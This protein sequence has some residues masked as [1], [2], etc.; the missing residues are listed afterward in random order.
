[1]EDIGFVDADVFE[2]TRRDAVL[3]AV[4]ANAKHGLRRTNAD[5]RY[6]VKLLLSDPE[7]REK[8]SNRWIAEKCA[9]DEGLVRKIK[10]ESGSGADC[11]QLNGK[12]KGRDGK[13]SL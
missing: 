13:V 5:K 6:S 12:R 7:W 2:G 9:V 8:R 11:P 10:G 3:Y 1:M 4:G